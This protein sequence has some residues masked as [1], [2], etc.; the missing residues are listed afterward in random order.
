MS[1]DQ[2]EKL[3][4][5]LA[6]ILKTVAKEGLP[7]PRDLDVALDAVISMFTPVKPLPRDSTPAKIFEQET[8]ARLEA[9]NYL[10]FGLREEDLP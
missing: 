9:E 7:H 2:E 10:A 1:D 4:E 8:E 3:R 6:E 5:E